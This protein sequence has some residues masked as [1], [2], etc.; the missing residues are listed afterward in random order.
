MNNYI[1]E[2]ILADLEAQESDP[3]SK[4]FDAGQAQP[5]SQ[6]GRNVKPGAEPRQLRQLMWY[7]R[8][9][10]RAATP[11]L[12]EH[13]RRYLVDVGALLELPRT[14]TDALLP[15][16]IS[17]LDDLIPIL[18]GSSVFREYSNGQAS[19][20]LVRAMCLVTCKTKQAVPFLR[21]TEDGTLL[22]PLDFSSKLLAGL[23]A[24]IKADLEPDRI[25]K[26][27]I[28]ALMHQH[29]DGVG[30]LRRASS[31]LSQAICEAWSLSLH[32]SIP[33]ISDQ[34]QCD[35][36]WWSL[37]N[38]DRLSKPIMAS[39]PFLTD[40]SD[41][42]IGRI[43]PREDSYRTQLMSISLRLGD[44][45]A[46]ATIVYKGSSKATADDEQAFPSFSEIMS[47]TNID[48]FHRSHRG[49]Q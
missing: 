26:V 28:L 31:H 2:T 44:L 33:G 38:L 15:I 13:H 29:N 23:D 3:S 41:V 48:R 47:G 16:Y 25:T 30:G 36:L 4:Q 8:H 10:R 32:F 9:K 20:Y 40:D 18:D 35:F 11:K 24:A 21:M 14:T 7:Q 27:Q 17:L 45:M 19:P 39:A 34:E 5:Q 43:A 49:K 37:R 22:Q 1:P 42:A 12:S 46:A 6:A